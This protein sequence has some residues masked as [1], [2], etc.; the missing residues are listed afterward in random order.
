MKNLVNNRY[1]L[2]AIFLCIIF[3]FLSFSSNEGFLPRLSKHYGNAITTDELAHIASGYYY[4]ETNRY[5]LNTEHPPLIKDISAMPSIFLNYTFPEIS[6]EILEDGYAWNNYPVKN[7]IYSKNLEKINNPWDLG[8]VFI[9]NPQNN[10]DSIIF[11]SRLCVATFN[12]FFL[13][14]LYI[15]L[16][17]AWNKKASIISLFLIIFSQFSLSHG[18]LVT[19]DFM[20]SILILITLTLFSL[21]L[22]S[23]NAK[24]LLITTLFLS[25]ALLAKFSSVVIIPTMFLGGIIYILITKH[26]FK[27]ITRYLLNYSTMCF[28][29]LIIIALYYWFHTFNMSPD[30]VTYQLQRYLPENLHPLINKDIFQYLITVPIIKGL[31]EY[32][33]G[34]IMVSSRM[35]EASQQIFFMG[36]IYGSEGAGL[37]Y[38]PILFITKLTLG[39]LVLIVLAITLSLKRIFELKNNKQEA[40]NKFISNPLSLNLLILICLYSIITLSSNLQIGLRHIFPIILATTLLIAKFISNKWEFVLLKFIKLKY[41]FVLI[42]IFII[43]SVLSTFPEYINYYNYLGGNTENGYKIATDSNYDWGGQNIKG[44]A[45]WI[46][47]ENI[48]K[49][50]TDIQSSYPVEYYLG[51]KYIKYDSLKE[52]LPPS[53]SFLAISASKVNLIK[54]EKFDILNNNPIARINNTIFIY[55]I[56]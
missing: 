35:A 38:F 33:A 39:F 49:I 28:L 22:I 5:F 27:K 30:E 14:L 12:T 23:S 47:T 50:Y 29:S 44:L 8:R 20:S 15:F 41:V 24:N 26:S 9:F 18:S 1:N 21:Y 42:F 13:F 51:D 52:D 43:Y 32:I 40:L 11:W 3:I 53:G 17:K 10:P 34:A 25:L 55:Q 46:E 37:L 19:M 48:S 54:N 7:Y 16:S 31:I 45:K 2:L 56:K 4:V 36:K 6:D